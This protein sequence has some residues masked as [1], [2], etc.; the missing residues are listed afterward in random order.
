MIRYQKLYFKDPKNSKNSKILKILK[1][2]N[3][4]LKN[5][6]WTTTFAEVVEKRFAATKFIFKSP[7]LIGY[8]IS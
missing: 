3:S 8:Y 1:F 5:K 7:K 2:K 6:I 4:I